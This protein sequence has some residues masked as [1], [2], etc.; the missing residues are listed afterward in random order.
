MD[1][2]ISGFPTCKKTVDVP[3]LL[4]P[5]FF[6]FFYIFPSLNSRAYLAITS[7][8]LSVQWWFKPLPMMAAVTSVYLSLPLAGMRDQRKC[9]TCF[10]FFFFSSKRTDFLF[11]ESF[12]AI[13][14]LKQTLLL[15]ATAVPILSSATH[16]LP[17]SWQNAQTHLMLPSSIK[18]AF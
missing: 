15:A 12:K 10:T 13:A 14:E 9:L 16:H 17:Q 1:C 18:K 5:I 2:R 7:S 8:Q 4:S 6:F 3:F 11:S